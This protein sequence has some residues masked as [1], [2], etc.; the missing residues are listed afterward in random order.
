M[1]LYSIVSPTVLVVLSLPV[2]PYASFGSVAGAIYYE[3]YQ[4]GDKSNLLVIN[5]CLNL[6]PGPP[7]KPLRSY[8]VFPG[9][10]ITCDF[11]DDVYCH[12]ARQWR[13]DDRS[14]MTVGDNTV[15]SILCTKPE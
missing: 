5:M 6:D 4:K 8:Y 15:K 1:I 10:K 2:M 12:G 11:F 9:N 7:T 13:A 14:D 3:Q